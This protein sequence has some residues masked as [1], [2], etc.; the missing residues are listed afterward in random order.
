[1]KNGDFPMNEQGIASVNM[2]VNIFL[3]CHDAINQGA[4][5]QRTSRQDKE[6]HFQNWFEARLQELEIHYDQKGR[7]SYPDFS[8]VQNPEGYEVKGLGWPGREADY[9]SNSQVPTGYHNGRTIYYVF[10][11]YPSAVNEN[12]YPVIDLVICHGD[13][14]NAA[15]EYVH[16]NKSFTGFGSYGDIKI[17]DRKMYIAPTP[18]GLL[19]GADRQ[20]TLILPEN[21]SPDPRLDAVGQLI[22]TETNQLI[23]GYSFDMITNQL[24]PQYGSNPSAGQ[25]HSFIAYRAKGILGPQVSLKNP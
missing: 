15:H 12:E 20:I 13:F 18:Y 19:H 8:L 7:N 14:L 11:R 1:M 3:A 10:G 5:I 2:C 21:S 4:L 25:I 9:D 23:V 6:F 17:R 22:R 16:K 24:T